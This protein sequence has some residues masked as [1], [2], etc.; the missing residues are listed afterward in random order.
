LTGKKQ[1]H[2]F[3]NAMTI[4]KYS[5]GYR[6]DARLQDYLTMEELIDTFVVTVR[7]NVNI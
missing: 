4:D 6:R 7:Y 1:N 2:K 5:W 3:E